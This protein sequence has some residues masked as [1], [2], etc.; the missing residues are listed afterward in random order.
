[1]HAFAAILSLAFENHH[2]LPEVEQELLYLN[3]VDSRVEVHL[4]A[5]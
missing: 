2:V 4:K 1:M 5:V 3:F